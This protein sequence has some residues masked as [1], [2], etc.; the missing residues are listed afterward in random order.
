MYEVLLDT[1]RIL[2]FDGPVWYTLPSPETLLIAV[3]AP[4]SY[5]V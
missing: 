1:L 3:R 5:M 4:S 2:F